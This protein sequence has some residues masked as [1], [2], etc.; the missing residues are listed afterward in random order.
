[1][2]TRQKNLPGRS[3]KLPGDCLKRGEPAIWPAIVVVS[4]KSRAI[5]PALV[6]APGTNE[7]Y[8]NPRVA[9]SFRLG[10]PLAQS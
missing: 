8:R 1:M 5:I 4:P 6:V 2:S 3:L 7:R 9:P 10:K